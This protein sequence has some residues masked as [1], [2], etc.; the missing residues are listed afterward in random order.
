MPLALRSLIAALI[1]GL[2]LGASHLAQA[3]SPPG[4]KTRSDTVDLSSTGKVEID[5]QTGSITVSTWGRPQVGYAV[6]LVP[7]ERDSIL[8]T[9]FDIDHSEE[10]FSVGHDH[11]WSIRIPGLLTISPDG[12][13]EPIGHY[14]IV[15]PKTAS[16]EIDDYESTIEVSG[17]E[18]ATNID[19]HDGTVRVRGAAGKL[20]LDTYS[21][22]VTATGLREG[23]DLESYSGGVTAVFEEFSASSSADTYSGP[24][25]FFLPTDAGF[26]L[27]TEADS[28]QVTIDE[29]FGAP[30]REEERWRFNGGGPDLSVETFSG[31]VELRPLDAYTP[32]SR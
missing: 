11:S 22:E 10:E 1:V 20:D 27:V 24:L 25:R 31:T 16:L 23:A 7:R 32:S 15:M 28:S 9:D 30:L 5:N 13:S 2:S 21:G 12:G 4:A 17:V 14:R 3:Q 29:A 18:G 6:T 8:S 26:T 19:T